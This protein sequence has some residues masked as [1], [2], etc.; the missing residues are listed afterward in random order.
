M[1]GFAALDEVVIECGVI[2]LNGVV[3]GGVVGVKGLDVGVSD[4]EVSAAN[5]A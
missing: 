5:A 2:R 4:G 3:D 1:A